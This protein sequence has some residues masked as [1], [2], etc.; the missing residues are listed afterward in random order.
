[1]IELD[2]FQ[3]WPVERYNQIVMLD[4]DLF[5]TWLV[6]NDYDRIK[7]LAIVNGE[8]G[9]YEQLGIPVRQYDTA[10]NIPCH[11]H[12]RYLVVGDSPWPE[13]ENVTVIHRHV[14]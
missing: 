11:P 9:R 8:P 13:S 1:M 3:P 4:E 12:W 7:E 5:A 14:Y 6:Y 2:N 10:E